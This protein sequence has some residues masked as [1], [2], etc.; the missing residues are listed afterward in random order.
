MT[1]ITQEQLD[2]ILAEAAAKAQ[3]AIDQANMQAQVFVAQATIARATDSSLTLARAKAIASNTTQAELDRLEASC[4]AIVASMPVY[5][6]KTRENR[7]FNSSKFYGFG[8]QIASL[9][10]LLSGINYSANDHKSMLLT[11]TGLNATTV[12]QTLDSLGSL[13]YYSAN[14]GIIVEG[15]PGNAAQ[16]KSNIKTVAAMLNISLDTS[17]ITQDALDTLSKN[18][19]VRAYT[20]LNDSLEAQATK[21]VDV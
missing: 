19:E 12:E 4:T 15:R 20:A 3:E 1:K 14:Y 11:T 21:T 8:N 6:K 7:K 17:A 18:A 2:A 13:P 9:V 5:N 10:G 16:F